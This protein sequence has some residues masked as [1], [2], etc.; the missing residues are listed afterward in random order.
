MQYPHGCK[1][2]FHRLDLWKALPRRANRI[3]QLYVAPRYFL[4]NNYG[5]K[6]SVKMIEKVLGPRPPVNGCRKSVY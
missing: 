6:R 3:N 2:V 4:Y 5:H 1:R